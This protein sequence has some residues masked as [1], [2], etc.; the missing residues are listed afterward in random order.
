MPKAKSLRLGSIATREFV[1][2]EGIGRRESLP[3]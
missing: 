3:L 1:A 2:I